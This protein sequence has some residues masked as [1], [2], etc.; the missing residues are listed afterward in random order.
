MA[1]PSISIRKLHHLVS[2]SGNYTQSRLPLKPFCDDTRWSN[3]TWFRLI[4]I[5]FA[6]MIDQ[7]SLRKI[8]DEV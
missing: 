3:M 2:L 6:K 7:F 1:P 4:C 5:C 8:L